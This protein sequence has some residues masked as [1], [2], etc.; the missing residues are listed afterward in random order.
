MGEEQADYLTILRKMVGE[1]RSAYQG[2]LARE[3]KQLTSGEIT[4]QAAIEDIVEKLIP[5]IQKL[6]LSI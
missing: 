4:S 1:D 6:N 3:K 2:I 5:A